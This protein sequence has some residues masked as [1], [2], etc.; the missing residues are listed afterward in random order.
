MYI[1]IQEK[2]SFLFSDFSECRIFSTDFRNI[3][4]YK[5]NDN[6]SGGRR[7]VPY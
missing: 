1:G 3:I 6:R 2:Y 4:E 7:A 5:F